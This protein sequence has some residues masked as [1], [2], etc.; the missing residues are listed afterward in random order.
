MKLKEKIEKIRTK[1]AW[2]VIK[3]IDDKFKTTEKITAA[4]RENSHM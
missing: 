2:E 1:T 4:L 3:N